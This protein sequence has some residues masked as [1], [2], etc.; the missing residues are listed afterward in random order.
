[1]LYNIF[2]GGVKQ[3][4]NNI[5]GDF[6]MKNKETQNPIFA[7]AAELE[8]YLLAHGYTHNTLKPFRRTWRLVAGYASENHYEEADAQWVMPFIRHYCESNGRKTENISVRA[9]KLLCDF[10][11]SKTTGIAPRWMADAETQSCIFSL[12]EGASLYLTSKSYPQST[13]RHY[14]HVWHQMAD[15][16]YEHDLTVIEDAWV[17]TFLYEHYRIA[18][19]KLS[20]TQRTHKRAAL[21]LRDFQRYGD[22]PNCGK[23]AAKEKG[24]TEY[25]CLFDSV[26]KYC[27]SKNYSVNTNRY[28][29]QRTYHLASFL[30]AREVCLQSLTVQHMRDY[31]LSL[32]G[33]AASTVG[34][35][36][37]VLR[38]ILRAAYEDGYISTD[39][40]LI[41]EKPRALAGSK[42]PSAYSPGDVQALLDSVDRDNP[43]GKRDYAILLLGA[44]L[45]LRA[46]DI[47]TMTFENFRWG[48]HEIRLTQEK[49]KN[50][51]ALPLSDEVG[52]AIIDYLKNGRPLADSNCI[53]VRHRAPYTPFGPTNSLG[54]IIGKY[55]RRANVRIPEG[56]KHGMHILRHSLASNM[57]A[58]G[59]PLPIL[60]EVLDHADGK[61][62]MQ[63]LKVD[64]SQLRGCA[65][66]IEDGGN[67]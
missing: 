61:T 64:T 40:S 37:Y 34:M 55:F 14:R 65:L 7:L 41:C 43:T 28:H 47:R 2:N 19:G 52:W 48:T 51:T 17:D 42:I 29:Q 6:N 9:C 59:V 63:Y 18:D 12:A 11:K 49:T 16:A 5:I 60:T 57:L 58:A 8:D 25:Q 23:R 13:I 35:A 24:F 45:G 66:E 27:S 30:S 31:F 39:L 3:R 26:E 67:C 4:Q 21:M 54:A 50:E 44:R 15:Y 33:L 20:G 32:S 1:M 56:K 38:N 22:I 36:H 10:Q 46:S 53:F 62:T